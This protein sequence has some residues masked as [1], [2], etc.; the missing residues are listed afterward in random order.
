VKTQRV[1]KMIEVDEGRD[2]LSTIKLLYGDVDIELGS[3]TP[4]TIRAWVNGRP[5]IL[6]RIRGAEPAPAKMEEKPMAIKEDE[7]GKENEN[8]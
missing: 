1:A 2:A 4:N 7:H 6:P 3:I 8:A 5:V